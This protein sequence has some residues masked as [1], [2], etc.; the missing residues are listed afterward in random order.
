VGGR[1]LVAGD[2]IGNSTVRAPQVLAISL[3]AVRGDGK[4]APFEVEG[5]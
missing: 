5:I 2:Y 4:I 3:T 1:A